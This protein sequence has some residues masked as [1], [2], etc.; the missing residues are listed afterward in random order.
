MKFVQTTGVLGCAVI[1]LAGVAPAMAQDSGWYGGATIGRTGASIDEDRIR[2]GLAAQGLATSSFEERDRSTG[3]RVFGGYQM[4]PHLAV[5]AGVFSLGH[6]GYTARTVPAGSLDGNMRVRGMNIDLVGTLPLSDRLA[7]LG[8]IGITSIR[9]SDQF[10]ATGAVAMPY[11][12]ASPS[13]RSTSY[14]A[15]LGVA[16]AFTDALSV[17]AEVERYGLKDA[18]GNKGHVDM[19]SLGLVYRFGAK[20]QPLRVAA[21]LPVY[22]AAAPAPMVRDDPAP[23]P[24]RAAPPAPPPAPMRI[25]L[26]ADALFDFDRSDLKPAGRQALEKLASDLRSVRYDTIAVTGH[27]DRLGGHDYNL[28]LSQRRADAVSAYLVQSGGVPAGKITARGVDGANPVTQPAQC[29]GNQATPALVAC[30]QPDR[31]VEVEVSGTR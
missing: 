29:K 19:L 22:V 9:A 5:E 7:A 23:A 13:E 28:K 2:A 4:T 1:G 17:R 30:L 25:T 27:T 18:V 16:Y 21:P 6:F 10:S 20:S 11:A 8:R 14:K 24:P 26:S 31:R 12:S 3:Y 15:G